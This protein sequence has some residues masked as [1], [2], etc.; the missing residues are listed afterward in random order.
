VLK[1]VTFAVPSLLSILALNILD[2]TVQP[3]IRNVIT[4]T[5]STGMLSSVCIAGHADPI[6]ESGTPR[7]I[8]AIYITMISTVAKTQTSVRNNLINLSYHGRFLMST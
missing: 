4:L 8:N 6:S 3:E 1:A 2:N 5:A 7:P